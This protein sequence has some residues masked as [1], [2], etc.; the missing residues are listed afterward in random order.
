MKTRAG[1]IEVSYELS[2]EGATGVS[3]FLCISG[4]EK[5]R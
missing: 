5:R 3:R 2:G 4:E 1:G